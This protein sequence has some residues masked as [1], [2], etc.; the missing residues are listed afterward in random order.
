MGD[1]AAHAHD[2]LR[3][4][5]RY[6]KQADQE[7]FRALVTRYSGLVY[8]TAMRTTG[9]AEWAA[10]ITQ[11]VFA[12]LG[13]KA[14][15]LLRGGRVAS[16]GA[17]LHRAATFESKRCLRDQVAG[18][19]RQLMI[20]ETLSN[21]VD[22]AGQD[23]WIEFRPRLDEALEKLP[24][25]DREILVLHYSD[26]LKFT[27][28]AN[29]LGLAAGSVQKRSVRAL[30]K[31]SHLLRT[32]RGAVPVAVLAASLT[33]E[34]AKTAPT[35]LIETICS[36]A[37]SA[38]GAAAAGTAL[39][40]MTLTK[41]T[42]IAG[43]AA[44]LTIFAAFLGGGYLA[45]R[46][47]LPQKA[48]AGAEIKSPPEPSRT[49]TESTAAAAGSEP[50]HQEP[51][52]SEPQDHV[53]LLISRLWKL[54]GE[55]EASMTEGRSVMRA[56]GKFSDLRPFLL[57]VEAAEA[58]ADAWLD[59][60]S[61]GDLP[62][63]LTQVA[64]L[65]EGPAKEWLIGVLFKRWA[66]SSPLETLAAAESAGRSATRGAYRGW[67]MSNPQE[68]LAHQ[69]LLAGNDQAAARDALLRIFDGWVGAGPSE[70]MRG[71]ESLDF[72]DQR[73]AFRSFDDA[74]QAESLRP[75][76]LEAVAQVEDEALR[77]DLVLDFATNWGQ[78]SPEEA[79]AWFDTL[80]FDNPRASIPA[81]RKILDGLSRAGKAAEG[82]AWIWPK[83]PDDLRGEFVRDF[84]AGQWSQADREGAAA[85]R[86]AHGLETLDLDR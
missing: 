48:P 6:A 86:Q 16:V 25:R 42:T 51:A 24:A 35:S 49:A 46:N 68:A 32:S 77:A 84:V 20:R 55:R 76:L 45:G 19:R 65:E 70:A 69:R 36:A 33:P 71:L 23:A 63:A 37:T 4:L 18:Q 7:A 78:V 2:D 83:L 11:N 50:V 26:G 41:K 85:W 58:S 80:T 22:D 3:L 34:L 31:L 56:G 73:T 9:N 74:L 44:A 75:Q 82:A 66:R 15:A 10:D 57:K 67:G 29:R 38:P 21:P 47:T 14:A 81:A 5:E 43:V 79:Q 17:W 52:P 39:T 8:G 72:D 13:R 27:E 53:Q 28:I 64:N 30:E 1:F 61:D 60:L 62:E 59:A 54:S 12:A 40:A